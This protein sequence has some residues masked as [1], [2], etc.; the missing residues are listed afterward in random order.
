MKKKTIWNDAY[1]IKG[2]NLIII[3][4]ITLILIFTGCINE[5]NSKDIKDIIIGK[6]IVMT[7]NDPLTFE[8]ASNG[9]YYVSNKE[10][11]VSGEY[12][13]IDNYHMVLQS[14][15]TPLTMAGRVTF[16]IRSSGNELILK[17]IEGKYCGNQK[18]EFRLVKIN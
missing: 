15:N 2:E 8:F 7:G 13:L 9:L 18:E 10:H 6:W 1:M 12:A 11:T 4:S 17:C 14:Y 16:E 5:N 3:V